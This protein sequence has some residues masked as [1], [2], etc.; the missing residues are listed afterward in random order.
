MHWFSA[1]LI[2]TLANLIGLPILRA[3][4]N[5]IEVCVYPPLMKE[6]NSPQG[7]TLSPGQL[8]W[9]AVLSHGVHSLS[10]DIPSSPLPWNCPSLTWYSGVLGNKKTPDFPPELNYRFSS[11]SR[12]FHTK[13]PI[14]GR[15]V[16]PAFFGQEV[17]VSGVQIPVEDVSLQ[18]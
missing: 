14:V 4:F 6:E 16:L 9:N 5:T 18:M 10:Y 12:R 11:P 3:L 2:S 15:E 7:H 8:F 13:P 1:K 17:S